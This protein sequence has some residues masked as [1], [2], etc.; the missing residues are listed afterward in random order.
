M[1][2]TVTNQR[3]GVIRLANGTYTDGVIITIQVD[4]A[5]DEITTGVAQVNY[6]VAHVQTVIADAYAKWQAV[7]ALTGS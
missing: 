2:W 5:G 3:E 1:G 6:N 7:Q 4:D